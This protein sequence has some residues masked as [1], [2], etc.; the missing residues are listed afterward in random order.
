MNEEVTYQVLQ[1]AVDAGVRE[2]IV[3]P[4]QR[5]ASFVEAL[6]LEERLTTYY[7]PEERSAAFFALGRAR[8][9]NR[10]TA[11]IT[12]SGTAVGELLPAAMEAHHS[13]VPLLLITADR[14]TRFRGSGAPQSTYQEGVFGHFVEVFQDASCVEPCDLSMWKKRWGAH[15]NVCLEEP[16]SQPR[17]IG[18]LLTLSH[19]VSVPDIAEREVTSTDL[20]HFFEKSK[21]PIIIVSTLKEESKESVAKFLIKAKVPVLL[22][23]MSGLREDPRL[24]SLRIRRTDQILEKARASGYEIDGVLRIGG[25]PTH[26]IWRDLEYCE[27][28]VNLCS[29]SEQH[30]SGL[31]WSRRVI[32]HPLKE[33]FGKYQM[34]K[35]PDYQY[36]DW[37][38]Q[39]SN[40]EKVLLE[41]FSNEE[42]AEMSLIYSLSRIIPDNSH[43]YLGNSLPVREWDTASTSSPKNFLV[44]ASRGLNGIDGQISTFLGLCK[45]GIDNWG[46]FGD[47]TTLYDMAALWITPQLENIRFNIVVINNGGGKIFEKFSP[48]KEMLNEHTLSFEPLA[49]MWGLEYQKW[50]TVPTTMSK[51][52][53]VLIEIIP[54]HDASQRLAALMANSHHLLGAK[55]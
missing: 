53:G 25:I 35:L 6:R 13:G 54:N 43:V 16:Q 39:E 24:Q 1:Q 45:P 44:T 4:G 36:E 22:E 41:Y 28:S 19:A 40:Y 42:Q 23:A 10:P 38:E 9:T 50:E 55:V 37:L 5:N 47:L 18:K 46:I 7:W 33:F 51:K 34:K 31:S 27:K 29:V 3:C 2:F 20:D 52:T 14:P 48:H 12:T 49:K 30:F 11:V 17:F 15:V 21:R 8:E 26:R 32:C